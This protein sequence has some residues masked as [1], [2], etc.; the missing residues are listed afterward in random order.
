[1]DNVRSRWKVIFSY[2]FRN[3]SYFFISSLPNVLLFCFC[4]SIFDSNKMTHIF[5]YS[6]DDGNRKCNLYLLIS[7]YSEQ[8]LF[9][10]ELRITRY[11]MFDCYECIVSLLMCC[12]NVGHDFQN[13]KN[14]QIPW[15]IPNEWRSQSQLWLN[16]GESTVQKATCRTPEG[17]WFS[18]KAAAFF[19]KEIYQRIINFLQKYN[20]YWGLRWF[21]HI[22]KWSYLPTLLSHRERT[23]HSNQ[24]ICICTI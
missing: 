20:N 4:H 18:K 7:N 3:P 5:D 23:L 24:R 17:K 9:K 10:G 1:M 19:A 12:T 21:Q 2:H 14:N 6:L 11:C 8:P 15:R 16:E 13:R 22:E